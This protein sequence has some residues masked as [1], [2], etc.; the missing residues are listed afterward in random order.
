MRVTL[1]MLTFDYEIKS[2]QVLCD[3]AFIALFCFKV[4][5][6]VAVIYRSIEVKKLNFAQP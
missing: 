3:E 4:N 5:Y 1:F 2:I 6:C